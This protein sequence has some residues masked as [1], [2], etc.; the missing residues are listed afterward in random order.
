[1]S[2][3]MEYFQYN[4]RL[5]EPFQSHKRLISETIKKDQKW[6]SLITDSIFYTNGL[7]NRPFD[8]TLHLPESVL[9]ARFFRKQQ[10][11]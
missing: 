8:S 9:C 2:I 6:H 4:Y 1:I 11:L 3:F 7:K 5:S 10:E